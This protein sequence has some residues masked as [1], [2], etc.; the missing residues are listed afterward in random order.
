MIVG[1]PKEIK[2][3]EYR[4]ALTP[5][6][7][8]EFKRRRH[9]VLIQAGAGSGSGF[10]DSDYTEVGAGVVS[11]PEEVYSQADMIVKVKEPLPSEFPLMREGQILYAFLHLAASAEAARALI[12]RKVVGIAYETVQLDDG[13][14]PLLMPMSEIAGRMAVQV[15][16]HFLERGSG[17][18]GI[19]LGEVPGVPAG[20]VIIIGAGQVGLGAARVA[21]GMG[22]F[23]TIIDRDMKKLRHVEDLFGSR[24]ATMAS[25][26]YNIGRAVEDADLLIGG[27]LVPGAKT[28]RLVS[29]EMVV[30]MKRGSVIVDVSVDQGGCV[31]TSRVTTHSDPV[32]THHGV[33]HYGVANMPGA[34]PRTSTHALANA[35][36]GYALAIADLGWAEAAK[37]DKALASGVNTADGRVVHRA[38]AESLGYEY[39]ELDSIIR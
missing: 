19:L 26:E 13:S 2:D 6:G 11:S 32:F 3:H 5:A 35:T 15:G 30:K 8:L 20:K 1:V 22:A 34:V 23:V 33:I 18:R 36:L 17:G 37:R 29:E 25:N 21:A 9:K 27:V 39:Y 38:V 10:S 31:A 28:P 14:L 24:V 12:E 7:A 16:A 4:V